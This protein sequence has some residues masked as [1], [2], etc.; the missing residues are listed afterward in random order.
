MKRWFSRGL[1]VPPLPDSIFSPELGGVTLTPSSDSRVVYVDKDIGN[2]SNDGLWP[3]QVGA[4]KG[5]VKTVPAGY[6]LIRDAKPDWLLLNGRQTFSGTDLYSGG[7][8]TWTKS[9]RGPTEP[10]VIA[11]YGTSGTRAQVVANG[12]DVPILYNFSGSPTDI[13]TTHLDI[14]F[15]ADTVP[16]PGQPMWGTLDSQSVGW[17]VLTPSTDTVFTYV[18]SSAGSDTYDGS[19]PDRVGTTNVGPKK[20]IKAAVNRMRDQKPDWLLLRE[21]DT[22]TLDGTNGEFNGRIEDGVNGRWQKSGR[23][24]TER[25]VLASYTPGFDDSSAAHAGARPI[26]KTGSSSGLDNFGGSGSANLAVVGW[27]MY[28]H[29]WS[30][31]GSG[32]Q[33]PIGIRSLNPGS[34]FLIENCYIHSYFQAVNFYNPSLMRDNIVI[35]R[36]VLADCFCWDM[37]ATGSDAAACGLYMSHTSNS[38]VEENFFIHNGWKAS[39]SGINNQYRRNAYFDEDGQPIRVSGNVFTSCDGM[40]QRC[41]G[42]NEDNLFLQTGIALLVG[43]GDNTV[44]AVQCT[45]QGNVY[46]DGNNYGGGGDR[47]WGINIENT[48]SALIRYNVWAHNVTG[49]AAEAFRIGLAMGSIGNSQP[50]FKGNVWYRWHKGTTGHA[51]ILGS[52]SQQTNIVFTDNDMQEHTVSGDTLIQ[53]D[54]LSTTAQFHS[55]RNR[56]ESLQSTNNWFDTNNGSSHV[57]LTNYKIAVL[58]EGTAQDDTTSTATIPSY[59]NPTRTIADFC[60][61]N[62]ISP[63]TVAGFE[64]VCRAVSRINWSFTVLPRY[65]TSDFGLDGLVGGSPV[66]FQITDDGPLDYFQGNFGGAIAAQGMTFTSMT[67]TSGTHLGG[68]ATSI[69]GSGFSRFFGTAS[70]PPT[71]SVEFDGNGASTVAYVS[72]T[73]IDV[74]TPAVAAG[75]VDVVLTIA[76]IP[77]TL[78]NG[79]TFT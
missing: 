13:V 59:P 45:V 71:L 1:G 69:V 31:S 35:R 42:I 16:Q 62:G 11:S 10:I 78:T 17:T 32:V 15:S 30:V 9:G 66:T 38:V 74:I 64:D 33:G 72:D 18:S 34:N 25:M 48:A 46:L 60:T 37:N 36:N 3:I 28:P 7:A 40:Q 41:G 56:Y 67:V 8:D 49:N 5:P 47:G 43:G 20:T 4:L 24:N 75:A 76:N 51:H 6:A 73:R 52:G 22:F 68:T 39:Q 55:A 58:G 29:V 57:S 77:L 53:H 61:A 2:D 50:T 54:Q 44:P 65:C 26:I 19:A 14:E 63:A 23:S 70:R 27:E 12:T 21:G 79:Y